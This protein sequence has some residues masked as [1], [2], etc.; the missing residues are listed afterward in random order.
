[1]SSTAVFC[2]MFN[3]YNSC[4]SEYRTCIHCETFPSHFPAVGLDTGTD[5]ELSILPT[6]NLDFW[7]SL[8]SQN[9]LKKCVLLEIL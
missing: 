4:V 2:F 6:S 9:C 8:V 7:C 5:I 3:G 1:M